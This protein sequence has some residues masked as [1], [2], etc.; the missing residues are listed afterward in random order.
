MSTEI[1]YKDLPKTLEGY[2]VIIQKY[3]T[4][5][6]KKI[7]AGYARSSTYNVTGV[8]KGSFYISLKEELTVTE[9]QMIQNGDFF[10]GSTKRNYWGA[11]L[12]KIID[13][14]PIIE[15]EGWSYKCLPIEGGRIPLEIF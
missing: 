6:K 15:I 5:T 2:W 13:D 11:P 10:D 12:K 14:Y 4:T 3:K 9:W 8:S 1:N 7:R